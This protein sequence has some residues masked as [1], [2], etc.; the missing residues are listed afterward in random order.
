VLISVNPK[1]GRRSA[2]HRVDRLEELLV[3]HGFH[4]E[5][6]T[7]L[8]EVSAEANRLHD[9][10]ELRALVGVGGDGT[11]A[12]LTNRTSQ[13]VPITLLTAGTANLL[14]K[15]LGLSGKPEKLCQTITDGRLLQ[16]DA[17][18]ASGR[19]FLVML[20]CGFDA[21]VVARVHAHREKGGRGGHI[22]YLSYLK[23][24]VK[25]IR[26]YE[27]PEIRV[28]CDESPD[29]AAEQEIPPVVGRWAFA[30]NLPRYGW[31]VPLAPKAVPTDGLLDLCSLG[32][33]SLVSGLRY[34]FAMQFGGWHG[35]LAD[36][37]IRTARRLRITSEERVPYQLDGDPG[38]VLPLEVEVLTNR[39]TALVPDSDP[40]PR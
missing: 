20:G 27:Y 22:S 33:G 39:V 23:P 37:E 11:A 13:G 25:S 12:E 14:S 26:S 40:K 18:R 10:G 19:L 2:A 4:V 29:R 34:A 38:G 31:G 6:F 36:C 21:D 1:A 9:R 5:I 16:F 3:E 7:D 8:A 17:G 35:R 24:I 30:C 15:H 32:R 28:Y